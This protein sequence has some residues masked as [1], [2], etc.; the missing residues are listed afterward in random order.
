MGFVND[1]NYVG[2]VIDHLCE[3]TLFRVCTAL[4]YGCLRSLSRAATHPVRISP[5]AITVCFA[6]VVPNC[7]VKGITDLLTGEDLEFCTSLARV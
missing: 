3:Q 2:G 7:M 5:S 4:G 1:G 6:D